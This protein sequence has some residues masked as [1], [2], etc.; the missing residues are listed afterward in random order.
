MVN[1]KSDVQPERLARLNHKNGYARKINI[2]NLD[3]YNII[4]EMRQSMWDN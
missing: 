1:K 2:I 3:D 4:R